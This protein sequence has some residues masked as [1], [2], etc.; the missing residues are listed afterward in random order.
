MSLS[1][2]E[3]GP[4]ARLVQLKQLPVVSDFTRLMITLSNN[5][6]ATWANN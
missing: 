2:E 3:L 4:T 6:H 1:P 5:T